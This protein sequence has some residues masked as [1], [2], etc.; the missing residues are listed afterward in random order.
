MTALQLMVCG[1]VPAAICG[2]LYLVMK[3]VKL[4]L[5]YAIGMCM[6]YA[7][8]VAIC[9]AFLLERHYTVNLAFPLDE[10]AQDIDLAGAFWSGWGE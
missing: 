8:W 2:I 5:P 7:A 10:L 9:R 4:S 1:T 6:V 3:P